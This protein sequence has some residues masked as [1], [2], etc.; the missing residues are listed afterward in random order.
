MLSWEMLRFVAV[1]PRWTRARRL[2]GRFAAA[3]STAGPL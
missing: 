3:R 2:G 1:N